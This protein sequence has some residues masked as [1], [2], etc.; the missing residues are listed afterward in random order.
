M[1]PEGGI[2]VAKAAVLVASLPLLLVSLM[3]C[4]NLARSLRETR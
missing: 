2:K 3:M 1:P 4:L